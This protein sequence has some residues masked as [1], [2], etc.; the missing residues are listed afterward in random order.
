MVQ[1][2]EEIVSAQGKN[3]ITV[4]NQKNNVGREVHL[5]KGGISSQVPDKCVFV[6][7]TSFLR[8][9]FIQCLVKQ[10]A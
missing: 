10:A 5:W 4:G 2:W 6:H 3:F 1:Q 7:G 8:I 9:S